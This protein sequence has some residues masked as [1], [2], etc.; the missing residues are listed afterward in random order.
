MGA[1]TSWVVGLDC[2]RTS[3]VGP[4]LS[5]HSRAVA[6][7]HD[8]RSTV[9]CPWPQHEHPEKLPEFEIS[10]H[11]RE[12]GSGMVPHLMLA[13]GVSHDAAR[14]VVCNSVSTA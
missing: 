4:E 12:V 5:D 8:S 10:R 2:A 3:L 9:S 7:V 1:G 11:Q 14:E 13:L 6:Q